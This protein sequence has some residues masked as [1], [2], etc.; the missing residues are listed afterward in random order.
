MLPQVRELKPEQ[1]FTQ[2]PPRFNEGS[3]VKAL[4][5]N[6]IGRPSTYASII[7]VLQA[8]DYV[9]KIEGRFRPT[10]L[11]RRLVDKLLHPVF[12]DILDVE[13]TARMEDQ[14]DEIEKGKADYNETLAT[15]YKR[16]Q[17][18]LKRAA[19]EMPN[20]KEG[21][22]TGETCDKCGRAR[23]WR[24]PASSASSSP[25][26]AIRS[27]TTPQGTRAGRSADRG[28]RRDLRELRQADGRQARPL[29]QFLA[30]TG[31]PECKTTRKIIATKQGVSAAKPDQI[32]EEKCPNCGKNL[33]VKQGRFG[34]FT[35][36]TGY[37]DC[38]YVKLQVH[39]HRLS[40]GR[41]RRGRTEV[42]ARQ[43][44]LRLRELSEMRLHAVEQAR[45]SSRAPSAGGRS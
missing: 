6:G 31:Y 22:P 15:F 39:R 13:Y 29:R 30:C 9:N 38:K 18:D 36:C 5:E 28:T 10:V 23:W 41:R 35:A 8:R 3:L 34:E 45:C 19:K 1:K 24:R 21:Q 25:A 11:G 40:E 2:P 26:A 14:L 37:P 42:A 16:F 33:V 7:G 12:D 44:V 43:G 20:F 4:E 27:A 32:L 17:K